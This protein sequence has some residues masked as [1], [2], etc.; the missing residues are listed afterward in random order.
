M[1]TVFPPG[2]VLPNGPAGSH[3][4]PIGLAN[5]LDNMLTVN[6]AADLEARF[7]ETEIWEAVKGCCSSK[8]PGPDGFNLKFYKL[9]WDVIKSVLLAAIN[10][11]WEYGEISKGC[12]ASFITLVPKKSNP[13]SLNEYRPISLI[14]SYYKIIAKLLSNRLKKVVPK[15]VSSE[16]SAFIKGRNIL[17][18]AL[19]AN[20][21]LNY[22]KVKREKGLIFKVDFEK[23]FDSLSWD[24]LEEMMSLM[25]FGL[26]WR[27]WIMSSLES[28][29]ISIL[30]NGSPTCEFNLG[31]GVRQGDPLSPF[32]FILAAEGLNALTKSAVS[33]KLFDGLLIGKDSVVLSHLQ[34]ADDTI[35]FGNESKIAWVKWEDIILPYDL[36]GLNLGSLRNKNLSLICKWWWRFKTET[37]TLWAKIIS[38]IYGPSGGLGPGGVTSNVGSSCWT[39][40]IKTSFFLYEL[41]LNFSLSFTKNIG[42]GSSV[43]F[44]NDI[45]IGDVCLKDK[46]SRLWRIDNNQDCTVR[47]R[48]LCVENGYVEAWDWIRQPRGRAA[49]DLVNFPGHHILSR[50]LADFKFDSS[51]RD[52]WRWHPG[53]NG[54][55]YTS[56]LT[57][58]ID[59][60]TLISGANSGETLR[61]NLTPKK[62]EIFVWRARKKRLPILIELDKRGIDLHSVRCPLCD[63]DIE[64]VD[65]SILSC[66]LASEVWSKVF[67]WWGLPFHSN[68]DIG[69]I[70]VEHPN[71]AYSTHSSKIW[72]AVTWI[73][74]YLIWGNRNRKVF[75]GK[76]WNAPMALCEI[77]VKT[78]EWIAR[79][80]KHKTI[81]W[82]NWLH[83]PRCFL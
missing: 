42:D 76:S 2:S 23:A 82:H 77:Q 52:S 71:L 34:Y 4:G 9:Y 63:G 37:S 17:D 46:F 79:R 38:S 59:E 47:D 5:L 18:G 33:R 41:G 32:L 3:Y 22:I 45:W 53:S 60:K 30:V 28:A 44:W 58:M 29:S 12:N 69:E 15:L 14:G 24:F 80:C 72:Q 62:V 81:D 74:G 31:R 13:V 21:A 11:F 49:G 56:K 78:H 55:F 7:T 83:N 73:C 43:S 25:G 10:S 1:A 20:E 40:I 36:G 35:F 19:I 8:A 50:L 57:S 27:K 54:C 16:H 70:F 39:S 26:K 48:L 65:H 61:N 68:I 51:G 66:K 67:D 64:S 6:E 75:K